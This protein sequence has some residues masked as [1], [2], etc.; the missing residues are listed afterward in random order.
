MELEIGEDVLKIVGR[1]DRE[2]QIIEEFIFQI[3]AIKRLNL[4]IIAW[5]DRKNSD[6]KE[7]DAIAICDEFKLAIEHTSI[8]VLPEQ[9]NDDFRFKQVF[10]GLEDELTSLLK[11]QKCRITI[12]IPSNSFVEG[13]KW[14]S[15]RK[16][17]KSYIIE[18]ISDLSFGLSKIEIENFKFKIIKKEW[19][20]IRISIGRDIPSDE[21]FPDRFN[22]RIL[23]KSLK[24]TKYGDSSW[25]KIILIENDDIQLMSEDKIYKAINNVDFEIMNYHVDEIWYGD[26]SI[27]DSYQ[28]W[29]LYDRNSTTK[30][31]RP[32]LLI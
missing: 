9:R 20:I 23:D 22:K 17:V 14:E 6:T 26:S 28:F 11:G 27:K 4:K 5:P 3:N 32:H 12:I 15:L 31:E 24:F 30:S 16:I 7:I 29:L 21:T 1:N 19:G 13:I 18:N 25:K 8:D 10:N 2:Q